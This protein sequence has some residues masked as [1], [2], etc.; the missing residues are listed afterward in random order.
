[1]ISEVLGDALAVYQRLWRRSVVVA[2][3]VFAVVSL[4]DA[5][6]AR[7]STAATTLVSVILALVGGLLVQGALV[8]VVRDLHE[9]REPGPVGAYY[10]ST[11][12]RLGTLLGASLLYGV[13]VAVGFLLLIVPGL[14]A[15]ARWSLIVP[16]VMIER[17]S[18]GEA[19]ARSRTLVKGQTGRVLV[20]VVLASVITVL[21]GV[22]VQ[23]AFGFLPS[24]GAIWIGGTIAS[25]VAVPY[26][27]HVLTVLYYRLTDPERP[28]L[29]EE[30]SRETW[31]S[32]WD[33]DPPQ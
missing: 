23:S 22:A 4:A 24:F 3:L 7:S 5:L 2:G 10:A 21:V 12:D 16:L 27:A 28:V 11:R 31:R 17:L 18:V 30:P 25:A 1:V 29:P 26:Q 14:I 13:G 6:A 32:I 8:E 15:V 20:L 33:E 9:G 19:F